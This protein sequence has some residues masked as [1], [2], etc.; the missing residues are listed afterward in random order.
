M[1]KF[2]RKK[3]KQ[4]KKEKV[5][6]EVKDQRSKVFKDK[7][8]RTA[9]AR[10]LGINKEKKYVLIT[11]QF[12][13]NGNDSGKKKKVAN[14]CKKKKRYKVEKENLSDNIYYVKYRRF[15]A[16][17]DTIKL[18]VVIAEIYIYKYK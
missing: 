17:L 12:N 1:D 2:L 5:K 18:I 3:G 9:G 6:K 10:I 16:E 4:R 11:F 15:Y 13:G 14:C 8:L 7:Y